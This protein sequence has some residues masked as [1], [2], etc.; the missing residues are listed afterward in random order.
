M[1]DK[2]GL[3]GASPLSSGDVVANRYRVIEEL[4]RGGYAIVYRAQDTRTGETIALKTIRPIAPRPDEVRERFRREAELV[5]RLKHHNTVRVFDYGF[6]TDFYLAMEFLEGSPL[7]DLL[8]G[9][10][11]LDLGRS[12]KITRGVLSSLAE[13]HRLGIVHRDLKPENVFLLRRPDEDT[14]QVKVLD[15]GIAKAL[16]D[17]NSPQLTLKGRAMG[18]PAY[19]SPEQAKGARLTVHSDLYAVAVLFYEMVCGVPP[20]AGDSAMT[21]MLKHVNEPPPP[22]TIPALQGSALE[23][24]ILRALAKNP[25]DRFASAEEFESALAS[26]A[27]QLGSLSRYDK[28]TAKLPA[29][30][31]RAAEPAPAAPDSSDESTKR[32]NLFASWFKRR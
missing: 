6:E 15:F 13:A 14:E 28:D 24:T 11:G 4:G 17:E 16:L 5:S 18:T 9:H 30:P 19:M 29:A 12:I 27:A 3:T 21:I 23:K 20:F 26:A 1:T 7:S 22:L 32:D 10:T 2:P 25:F 8:D 31:E